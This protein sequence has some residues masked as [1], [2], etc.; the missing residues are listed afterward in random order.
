MH[1]SS[2]SCVGASMSTT[3]TWTR[4]R[5]ASLI[6][7]RRGG[8]SVR[9][10][11]T[12]MPWPRSQT[13]S[14]TS[15][16]RAMAASEGLSIQEKPCGCDMQISRATKRFLTETGTQLVRLLPYFRR[17]LQKVDEI[18]RGNAQRRRR[19]ADARLQSLQHVEHQAG[20]RPE[21]RVLAAEVQPAGASFGVAILRPDGQC[22]RR[23]LLAAEFLAQF[24]VE[25]LAQPAQG[26]NAV[27]VLRAALL[28]DH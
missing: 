1:R 17:R 16:G 2:C 8:S 22:F 5:P 6:Q 19:L 3:G 25:R 26:A 13:S 4:N 18:D 20:H 14:S 28:R 23:Q 24:E 12:S 21:A 10:R 15:C 9:D 27:L 11:S 7:S